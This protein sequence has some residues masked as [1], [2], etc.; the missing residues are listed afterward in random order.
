M[1]KNKR[2]YRT[3]SSK[4]KYILWKFQKEK[5]EEGTESLLEEIMDEYFPNLKKWTSKSRSLKDPSKMNSKRPMPRHIVIKLSKDK[6]KKR[7]LKTGR[8]K[9]YITCKGISIRLSVDFL[10]ETL[11]ARGNG[12]IDSKCW[13]KKLPTKNT[14]SGKIVLQNWRRNK[15]FHRLR[16]IKES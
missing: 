9:Q 10:A 11:Q 15:D 3:P 1:K 16:N 6:H 2:T 14:I 4:T 5:R 13:N 7:I 8:T 12:M